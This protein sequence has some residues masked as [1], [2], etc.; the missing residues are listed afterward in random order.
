MIQETI[1]EVTPYLFKKGYT[2]VLDTS[3]QTNKKAEARYKIEKEV[4]DEKDSLADT[5]K[6]LSLLTTLV[7]TMYDTFTETQKAKIPTEQRALIE[8]TFTK[9]KATNTRGDVQFA[10]E[11]TSMVDKLLARQAQIGALVK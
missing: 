5:A 9:F 2:E 11:G 6:W 3:V 4:F 8:Y 1:K 7:S 10:Q